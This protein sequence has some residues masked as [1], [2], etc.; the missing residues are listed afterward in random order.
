MAKRT[1]GLQSIGEVQRIIPYRRELR[2]GRDFAARK[3]E[4]LIQVAKDRNLPTSAYRVAQLL[5]KWLNAKTEEAFPAQGTVAS[6]LNLTVRAVTN[7]FGALVN[8]GHL[9]KSPGKRGYRGTN[10][11]KM[12]LHEPEIVNAC[13]PSSPSMDKMVNGRS[14]MP[15]TDV[16]QEGEQTFGQ[17]IEETTKRTNG[18]GKAPTTNDLVSTESSESRERVSK[19]AAEQILREA[20]GERALNQHG[21]LRK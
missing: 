21:F 1:Q 18:L 2:S 14:H 10:V 8:R 19:E 9:S 3:T 12:E 11:Y 20:F 15:R 7:A 13:S 17:T 5:P 4:W 6:E 16:P